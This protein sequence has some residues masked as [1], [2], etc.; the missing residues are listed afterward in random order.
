MTTKQAANRAADKNGLT[1]YRKSNLTNTKTE[2]NASATA[3]Y[4]IHVFN[5][6]AAAMYL[7]LF[8]ALAANVTV[9]TTVPDLSFG[10][11]GGG[12]SL[13]L[14]FPL[15]IDFATALTIAS[16]TSATGS[17]GP[18]TATVVNILYK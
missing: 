14:I 16:T 11:P 7:Q 1:P 6:D 8:N 10:I 3:I 15:P 4:G 9:G 12:G 18:G 5:P 13:T 17:T 2:V